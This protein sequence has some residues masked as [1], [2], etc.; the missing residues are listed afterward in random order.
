MH[1]IKVPFQLQH[2]SIPFIPTASSAIWNQ[3]LR[4]DTGKTYHIKASSGKGKSSLI[5]TLYGLQNNYTGQ[6]LF[7]DKNTR[8]LTTDE[9]CSLRTDKLSIVF[10][11]LKLFENE[12]AFDNIEVKREL[13]NYY[14]RE[15]IY[16]FAERLHV[17]HT[18][19]RTI[20][21]LSYGERQRVA[22]VR[23]LMQNFSCIL[24][25]EP[26]SHLDKEN[27]TR[28]S[29]LLLEESRKRNATLIITDLEDDDHFPY[30]QK[31]FL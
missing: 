5:H 22:I 30:H 11:D 18:L 8:L 25:D 14:P 7:E 26:F 16:D 31:L 17:T 1:L 27:I 28:A 20:E 19:Q 29:E 9:W 6:L 2:I 15:K 13:S 23:S 24:L 3:T 4:F 12:T 21:T 10:Q